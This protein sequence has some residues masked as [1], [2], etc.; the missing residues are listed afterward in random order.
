VVLDYL[1]EAECEGAQREFERLQAAPAARASRSGSA[2]YD[3]VKAVLKG[4]AAPLPG[5][6]MIKDKDGMRGHDVCVRS[7]D[8]EAS[9]YCAGTLTEHTQRDQLPDLPLP[10]DAP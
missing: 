4:I 2:D 6:V 9:D 5:V 1:G 10:A 3:A 8:Q 7:W